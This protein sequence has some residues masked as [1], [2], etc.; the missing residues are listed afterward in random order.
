MTA[1]CYDQ[2]RAPEPYES[3]RRNALVYLTGGRVKETRG[4]DEK[5]AKPPRG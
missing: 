4:G 5:S 1:R 2:G 3:A